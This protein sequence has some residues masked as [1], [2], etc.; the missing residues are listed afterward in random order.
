MALNFHDGFET[1]GAEA[2]SSV[3]G[4]PAFNASYANTG[5]YGMRC[6][7]AGS[8]VYVTPPSN[9]YH[10]ISVWIYINSITNAITIIGGSLSTN[11]AAL[12]LTSSR[13]LRL[14]S[15]SGGDDTG[16]TQLNTGT[17][18]RI[19]V[20]ASSASG[21]KAYLNGV[22]ECSFSNNASAGIGTGEVGAYGPVTCDIYFDDCAYDGT[23]STSDLGNILTLAARPTSNGIDVDLG[24]NM[25]Q[26]RTGGSDNGNNANYV[27]L[28]DDPPSTDEG[29]WEEANGTAHYF[30]VDLDDCG[31]GNLA[32]IGGSDIIHAVNF[33]FYYE[34]DGGGT[35]AYY[36]YGRDT[37]G[38][39][40][41]VELD[42]LKAPTWITQYQITS[43]D[44]DASTWSQT[45]FDDQEV[46]MMCQDNLKDMWWYEAYVM[47]AFEPAAGPIALTGTITAQSGVSGDI[48][49]TK[50]ITGT[51]DAQSGVSG[52]IEV[53]KEI[54]GT[55][56]AQSIV[57]GD[58]VVTVAL[59]GTIA[60]QSGVSGDIEVTKEVTGTIDAQSAVSG[61]I[62]VE[63]LLTGTTDAQSVVS[64]DIEIEKLLTGSSA[65]Q[66]IVDGELTVQVEIDG[67][68]VAQSDLTGE[69]SVLIALTGSIAAQSGVSGD[70]E[71][72]ISLDGTVNATTTVGG[73]IEKAVALDGTIAAQSIADA[74]LDVE[75]LLTGTID[76]QSTVD[77]D[78]TLD[79][80][81]TGTIVAQSGVSGDIEVTK[82]VTGTIDAQSTV[83]GDIEK[84]VALDGTITAQSTADG[85]LTVEGGTIELTGAI[86]AQSGISGDIEVTK[87][88][89]GTVVAQ[90]AID[91]DIVVA[92]LLTGAVAAQSG[93]NA[94]LTTFAFL[95]GSIIATSA[96]S[97][98]GLDVLKKL[99]GSIQAAGSVE[100]NI[101]VIKLLT[102]TVSGVSTLTGVLTGTGV[103]EADIDLPDDWM[104]IAEMINE[105]GRNMWIT[106][107]GDPIDPAEPWRGNAPGTPVSA[108]GIFVGHEANKLSGD[109]IR[110]QEQR[111][112]VAPASNIEIHKGTKIVDTIDGSDWYVE[113]FKKI[114]EETDILLYI[115]KVKQ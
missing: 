46:G 19:S 39:S 106:V 4:T 41:T 11:E 13:Y 90:T 81:L 58:L 57:D 103:T 36:M 8:A 20:S 35:A 23:D 53:A 42:D 59:T 54:T 91:G 82:E 113:S 34:T 76:A 38:R 93:A 98:P 72:A 63:K 74:D 28:T 80:Q 7:A 18:Y 10:R 95:N 6:N 88:L 40:S 30:S 115:L 97:S 83:D 107:P 109:H 37:S 66:S 78:I 26:D 73:D 110:R 27:R 79:V 75:K 12:E 2:W 65:A 69:L 102:G 9:T 21:C 5:N 45:E 105:D 3:T 84:A 52:D 77:G 43:W 55:I 112:L 15:N 33:L 1:G 104:W 99:T 44:D 48:E 47:V 70:I 14:V 24:N 61:D 22:E 86:T 111:L 62:E 101:L 31:S 100:G 56:D 85:D 92:K 32:N 68:I 60:A 94:E 67:S 49:V 71:K 25:W 29:A 108:K 114:T 64:G 17:W 96:V 51:I 87:L 16:P 89:T 50:E